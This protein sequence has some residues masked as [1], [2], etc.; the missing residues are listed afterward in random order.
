MSPKRIAVAL[1][2]VRGTYSPRADK[3]RKWKAEFA[4]DSRRRGATGFHLDGPYV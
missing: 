3:A 4:D 2:E 1:D